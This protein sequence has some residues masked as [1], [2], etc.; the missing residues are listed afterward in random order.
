M[1]SEEMEAEI[2]HLQRRVLSCEQVL[3][4]H[5]R[6]IDGVKDNLTGAFGMIN[7]VVREL[8]QHL[9]GWMHL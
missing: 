6:K 8:E 7:G 1:T 4:Q 2:E 9:V 5:E 3:L